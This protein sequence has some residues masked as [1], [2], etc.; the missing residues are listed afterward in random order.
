MDRS[1]T[2]RLNPPQPCY[3][4]SCIRVVD[5]AICERESSQSR[6]FSCSPACWEHSYFFMGDTPGAEEIREQY[7]IITLMLVGYLEVERA[8]VLREVKD[9]SE[10]PDYSAVHDPV[11]LDDLAWFCAIWKEEREQA[12]YVVWNFNIRDWIIYPVEESEESSNV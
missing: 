7:E 3:V 2:V 6:T 4:P 5:L 1:F 11:E 9:F 8:E 12:V 10:I